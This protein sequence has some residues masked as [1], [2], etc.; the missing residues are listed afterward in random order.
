M[1]IDTRQMMRKSV[2]LAL[3]LAATYGGQALAQDDTVIYGSVVSSMNWGAGGGPGIYSFGTT[4]ASGFTPVKIDQRLTAQ[5]GGAYANGKY[6]SIN[7]D[8]M[9]LSVYD[10]DTWELL[11]EKT[12]AHAALDLAYDATTDK[13]YACYVDGGICLGTLNVEKG[14]FDR[15][16]DFDTTFSALFFDNSGQLYGITQESLVK[17]DKSNAQ[18]TVVGSTGIMPMYAQ[19]ATVDPTTGKCYWA[20]MKSDFTS[21]LYEVNMQSAHALPT[22]HGYGGDNRPLHSAARRQGRTCKGER[23]EGKFQ[24]RQ[25]HRKG[26]LHH[27]FRNTGR[28]DAERQHHL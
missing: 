8:K 27:A 5:G 16:A 17:I 26:Q 9:L 19:S 24:Q 3:F 15:I 1:K 22:V 23:P 2:A 20:S 11:S 4:S 18:Y 12:M 13:I 7:V 14:D 10:A 25:H 28:R 21:A 6:Y